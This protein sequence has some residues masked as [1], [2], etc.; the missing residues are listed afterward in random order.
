MT[1]AEA[2][3]NF[4]AGFKLPAFDET[5][6][7]DEKTRI[8]LF[9]AAFPFLSYETA[10]DYFGNE[11]PLAASLW[12]K[13]TSWQDITEKANTID[14]AIGRGGKILRTDAGAIWLKRGTP[15]AQRMSD[16]DDSIRRIVINC[17]AEF[18]EN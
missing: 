15:F 10:K 16:T 18:I 9:G 8:E 2:I 13:S 3:Y 4:W 17:T 11:I 1:S 5:S 12:Y 6:V 14:A 7:P